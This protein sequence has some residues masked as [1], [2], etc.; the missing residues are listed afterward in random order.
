MLSLPNKKCTNYIYSG[1]NCQTIKV[2]V[3]YGTLVKHLLYTYIKGHMVKDKTTLAPIEKVMY[4][5]KHA[6]CMHLQI[7]LIESI[8]VVCVRI[9]VGFRPLS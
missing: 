6:N 5:I 8:S 9:M 4:R 3:H 2:T 1:G 7:E